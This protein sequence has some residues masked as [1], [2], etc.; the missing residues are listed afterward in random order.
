[1]F[2]STEPEEMIRHWLQTDALSHHQDFDITTLQ[3]VRSR[4]DPIY[5]LHY[6]LCQE[7]AG[8]WWGACVGG[9]LVSDRTLSCGLSAP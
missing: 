8:Q 5:Q 2:S 1:M 6:V 7:K 3:W 9:S 4:R